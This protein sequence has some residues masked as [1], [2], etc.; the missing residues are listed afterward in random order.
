MERVSLQDE[1]G[2][3]DVT[4][5]AVARP[6]RLV[7]FAVG[8]GG[9]PERHAPL[10][11]ALLGSGCSVVA[12]HFERLASPNPTDAELL[13]RARRLTLASNIGGPSEIP[14]TGVGHSIGAT[15]LLA[16]AGAQLWTRP[17]QPLPIVP[18]GRID[19]LALMA[20]ATGFFGAPGALD[21]VRTPLA[22]WA[23]GLDTVTPQAQAQFLG[24]ALAT[25]VPVDLR[26]FEEA[27]HFSFM[28]V[29]PPHLTDPLPNRQ[30][31]LES[32]QSEVCRFAAR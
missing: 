30:A 13:L 3:Y 1:T 6:S 26:V 31:F 2:T 27:G 14:I 11:A 25:R 7:L 9:N 23:G 18:N 17:D 21:A 29:L 28:N 10:L 4:V 19:R 20:P 8:A 24:R 15:V 5:G 16:L 32:L 12:P 22:V